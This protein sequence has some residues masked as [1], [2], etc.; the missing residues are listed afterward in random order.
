MFLIENESCT[1][2]W[3]FGS[4]LK[5][6]FWNSPFFLLRMNRV[7]FEGFSKYSE[8]YSLGAAGGHWHGSPLGGRPKRG[9]AGWMRVGTPIRVL[10]SEVGRLAG[11]SAVQFCRLLAVVPA[12]SVEDGWVSFRPSILSSFFLSCFHPCD[13]FRKSFLQCVTVDHHQKH[14]KVEATTSNRGQTPPST[15]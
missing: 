11:L 3:V 7:F 4:I 10:A 15:F 8:V 1:H 5:Y 6:T 13:L 9:G 2:F 12:I 14:F